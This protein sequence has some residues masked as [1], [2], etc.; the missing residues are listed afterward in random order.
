MRTGNCT[1]QAHR[2]SSQLVGREKVLAVLPSEEVATPLSGSRYNL[3]ELRIEAASGKKSDRGHQ[4][5][6]DLV[7]EFVAKSH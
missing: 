1:F 2:E 5:F 6:I 7:D 3:K 4:T